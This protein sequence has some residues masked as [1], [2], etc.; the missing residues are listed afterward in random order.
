[1]SQVIAIIFFCFVAYAIYDAMKRSN[2]T[3]TDILTPPAIVAVICLILFVLAALYKF[4][5][6]Y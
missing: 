6:G 1:M 5:F 4:L 3:I 2:A